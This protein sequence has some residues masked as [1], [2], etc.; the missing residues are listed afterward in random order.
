MIA[1]IIKIRTRQIHRALA[2]VGI[3]RFVLL[4]VLLAFLEVFLFLAS[5]ENQNANYITGLF[6]FILILIQVKRKDKLFLQTHFSQYTNIFKIEYLL[7]ALPLIINF[8][9]HFKWLHSAAVILGSLL[10]SHINYVPKKRSF[11]TFFQKIIPNEMYEWKAG[12]RQLMFIITPLWIIGLSTSFFIGSVPVAILFIGISSLNLYEICEPY[13]M[14]IASEKSPRKF[15]NRK[16]QLHSLILTSILMP[17]VLAFILFHTAYWYIAV[18]EYFLLISINIYFILIKYA[19]YEPNEK[20][21]ATRIMGIVGAISVILPVFLP[22][23]LLLSVIFY[24]KS[25]EKLNYYLN[26]FN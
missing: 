4:L 16:I 7:F 21:A 12:S 18:V 13:Q 5:Q 10:I 19:Y 8:L 2:A 26:D 9:L 6:L 22:V 24:S 23:I 20:P 11:N 1:A 25:L 17:L 15:L 14:I 3:V